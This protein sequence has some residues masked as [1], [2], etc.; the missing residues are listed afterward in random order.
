[1][2]VTSLLPIVPKRRDRRK[3]VTIAPKKL[4]TSEKMM[5]SMVGKTLSERCVVLHRAMP[6][7]RI[8]RTTLSKIYQEHGV[9]KKVICKVKKVPLKSK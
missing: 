4:A 9:K 6:D 2:A 1:M 7:I 3:K 8:K 5:M